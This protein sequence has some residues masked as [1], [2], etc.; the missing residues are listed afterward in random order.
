MKVY[1]DNYNIAEVLNKK[2]NFDKYY[3]KSYNRID[4]FSS[5]GMFV[6]DKTSMYKLNNIIDKPLKTADK[7]YKDMSL[8]IDDS[9]YNKSEVFQLPVNH[10]H[11]NTVSF[12]YTI[13]NNKTK[14]VIEGTY[15]TTY[16]L[17]NDKYK[18]FTPTDIYFTDFGINEIN[19]FLMALN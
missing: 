18:G 15:D 16:T 7:F 5:E 4:I 14:M 19:V 6:I 12:I 1:I 9:S 17:V 11:I 8:I 10:I 3:E 2:N 13:N